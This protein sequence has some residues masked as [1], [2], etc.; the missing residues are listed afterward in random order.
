MYNFSWLLTPK[1]PVKSPAP[2]RFTKPRRGHEGRMPVRDSP[3]PGRAALFSPP[4]PC[5]QTELAP[6]LLSKTLACLCGIPT[7][8]REPRAPE[9]PGHGLHVP[10][11]PD[12]SQPA[13]AANSTF[14]P[15]SLHGDKFSHVAGDGSAP[16]LLL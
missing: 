1:C 12:S 5:L 9:K 14:R 8:G 6:H 3:S 11:A 7:A 15:L 10:A 16:S 13:P 2:H 4:V